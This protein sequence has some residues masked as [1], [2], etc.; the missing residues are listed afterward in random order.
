MRP[1]LLIFAAL[2]GATISFAQPS[3]EKDFSGTLKKVVAALSNRDSVTLSRYTDK[4]TG[5]YMLNRI[6]VFNTYKH[7]TT[8]GFSDSTYPNVPFYDSVKLTPLKY[9][10]L[11]RYDCEK[12][13]KTGTFV[14]TTR[15]DHLLSETAKYL[16][17]EFTNEV[18]VKTINDFYK[19][20]NKSRRIVI[21]ENNG[22]ELIIYLSYINNKW[23]LTIID[24]VT[25]DCST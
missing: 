23:V 9:A 24:K 6:G 19:L 22:N 4:S 20:E 7:Y 12:W 17:K 8:L 1:S 14:D 16:N 3:K 18:P 25:C 13:T 15:T 11:P 21:A 5:I 10:K 2:F